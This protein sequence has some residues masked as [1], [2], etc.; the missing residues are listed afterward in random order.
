MVK[1]RTQ[2]LVSEIHPL[3]LLIFWALSFFMK[4]EAYWIHRMCPRGLARRIAVV[5]LGTYLTWSETA[6]FRSRVV[7]LWEG[8]LENFPENS[9]TL[10][11][12]GHRLNFTTKAK[13]DLAAHFERLLLLQEVKRRIG[14]DS[15][16]YIIDSPQ[17]R[18]LRKLDPSADFFSYPSLAG[19]SWINVFL[20]LMF[21]YVYS[22]ARMCLRIQAM[23]HGCLPNALRQSAHAEPIPFFWD[24]VASNELTLDANRRFFPWIVDGMRITAEDVLFILPGH[25]NHRARPDLQ[26]SGYR[27]FTIPDLYKLIPVSILLS[28]VRDL[29]VFIFRYILPVPRPLASIQMAGYF[30]G[31]M[32]FKPAIEHLKPS[33]YITNV[34]R[35]G[36]E[37]PVIV[38]LNV[39]GVTTVMYCYSANAHM[40]AGGHRTCDLRTVNYGNILASRLVVWHEQFKEYVQEHPQVETTIDVI[41]PLM[42]G[43]ESVI[44]SPPYVLRNVLGVRPTGKGDDLRYISFF[45]VT[46]LSKEYKLAVNYYADPYTEEYTSAFLRD[47]MRLLEDFDNI[48]LIFKPKK[49][50]VGASF[51]HNNEFHDLVEELGNSGRGLMLD[52]D[53]NPWISIALA[54]LCIG[55]PF[56]SPPLAAMHY[57]IPGLFHDPTGIALH[58]RYHSVT[59]CITHDYDQLR[60]KVRSL[61]LDNSSNKGDKEV[62]WS[63]AR[64]LIGEY[65][66]TNSNERFREF[67]RDIA[68]QE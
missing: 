43:D 13:Q 23:L 31:V 34:S 50:L 62:V 8:V 55:M 32:K 19:I 29:L 27:A 7:Q 64:G 2:V 48:A 3:N 28:G 40:F 38:Y 65:P 39:I 68:V 21:D 6:W 37:D 61:V 9:W 4:V 54:D 30:A 66:G 16:V 20:G 11:H 59:Y 44:E 51:F 52:D 60:T 15:R 5:D 56:T 33:C 63:Q 41:G 57:G 18:Y 24:A 67:L 53:I 46:V 12:G 45:D 47:M 22:R 10:R 36:I 49:S 42:A 35:L 58:H 14:P 26:S 17:F 1:R 25:A